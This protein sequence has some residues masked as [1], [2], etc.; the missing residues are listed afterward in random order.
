MPTNGQAPRMW[1]PHEK[2]DDRLARLEK[3]IDLLVFY[4]YAL[5][6]K[7]PDVKTELAAKFR[8]AT[9]VSATEE[10]KE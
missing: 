10:P 5:L 6:D 3:K 1:P 8:E 7:R 4:T 2:T 9:T